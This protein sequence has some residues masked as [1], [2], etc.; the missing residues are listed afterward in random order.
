MAGSGV[1]VGSGIASAIGGVGTGSCIGFVCSATFCFTA[2]KYPLASCGDLKVSPG[3][4]SLLFPYAKSLYF[5][6]DH[7]L[8]WVLDSGKF[9]VSSNTARC[10]FGIHDFTTGSTFG[11]IASGFAASSERVG[12]ALLESVSCFIASSKLSF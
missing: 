4:I 9:G 8:A 2:L 6:S 1:A 3:K 11:A 7:F 5:P 12:L 10:S